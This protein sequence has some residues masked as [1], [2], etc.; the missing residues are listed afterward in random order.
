MSLCLLIVCASSLVLSCWLPSIGLLCKIPLHI[1]S[2][3]S[4]GAGQRYRERRIREEVR[5]GLGTQAGGP[6]R[7]RGGGQGQAK[8]PIE[9]G[10]AGSWEVWAEEASSVST[11]QGDVCTEG[12]EEGGETPR[13]STVW[14]LATTPGAR[15]VC[16]AGAVAPAPGSCRM[17]STPAGP[18]PVH[19]S[20]QRNG[21]QVKKK[22][23]D[24]KKRTRSGRL[25]LNAAAS[26]RPPSPP[27]GTDRHPHQF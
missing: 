11:R 27:S 20:A 10:K 1:S 26:Q 21:L 12:G 8:E 9:P 16:G 15:R 19:S 18:A 3:T 7:E 5:T 4:G 22:K 14:P 2:T 25:R 17:G 23:F 6:F 13:W 24:A